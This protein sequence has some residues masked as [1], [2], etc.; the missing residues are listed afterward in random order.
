MSTTTDTQTAYEKLSQKMYGAALLESTAA[1]LGWEQETYMPDGARGHRA[2][3]LSQLAGMIHEMTVQPEIGDLIAACEQ[4]AA[5]H[6]DPISEQAV[7][8][9]EWRR[10][11]DRA[12]KLPQSLV[13][14]ITKTQSLAQGEWAK[15]RKDSD[16][17][18]F[19]P[20]LEKIMELMRQKAECYGYPADGEPYD[21]LLEDY[22]PGAT[23]KEIESIFVPLRE[24]LAPLIAEIA[25]STNKP[26]GALHKVAVPK[27]KQK[28]L[29]KFV[30]KSLGFDFSIGR[31]DET[32][33]PFCSGIGP[34]DTRLTTRFRDDN[35]PD[36]L[37]ST[38]HETG[39]GLYEQGLRGECFGTPMGKSISL[40][41]HESQSR[42]WENQVGRSEAFWSWFAPQVKQLLG[43]A[44]LE[45]F[46][47]AEMFR[48][49][50]MVE[51]SFIRVESDEATYN[52]HIM[53]R[54]EL[55]RAL[56]RGDL[57]PADLPGVWNERF[58]AYLGVE[59][60][61][62][63]RG[64][65]Q[66]VHWA[67]GLVGYFPTYTLGNLYS[68][69]LFEKIS[70]DIPTLQDQF[71]QGEFAELLTWLREHIHH[72]GQRYRAKDL[73]KHVTGKELSA[74]PLL[75]HLEGKLRPVY[76]I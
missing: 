34:G 70:E 41:I 13:E 35:F 53:L 33:H 15:A 12:T 76:G 51:P 57:K 46:T 10:V 52:L 63:R 56:L 4:D 49:A 32:T 29:S 67:F 22:E 23:A 47:A 59:V 3:Q 6:A 42:M 9:R 66:D 5:L 11:Y 37:S 27:A 73:C 45:R 21:A 40:G 19:Q 17:P 25:G 14:E 30:S 31:L 69:Q 60:P 64:C 16:F 43:V 38:M 20:Y 50:N 75:R 28:E 55:E 24:K 58:Q 36:A 44:E 74:E 7:N 68:A 72:H 26:T 8:I 62:D 65:L 71:R 54:F 39:H 2:G 61:D 18:R 48:D 1:I